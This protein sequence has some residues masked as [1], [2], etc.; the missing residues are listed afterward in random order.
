M[1]ISSNVPVDT[2]EARFVK[3]PK[4]SN[5]GMVIYTDYHTLYV[6]PKEYK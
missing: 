6:N 4:G 5:P 2:C 3:K 1:F